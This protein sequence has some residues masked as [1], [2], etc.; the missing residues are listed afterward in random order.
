MAA[1]L[2]VEGKADAVEMTRALIADPELPAKLRQ[3]RISDI[4]PCL[5]ANQDNIIGLVQNPRLSCA[6]NPSAGYEQEAEFAPL[7]PAR[8]PHRCSSS[9]VGRQV[10]KRHGLLPCA[11]IA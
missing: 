3:G 4:R 11:A 6:N 7:K 2:L 10:W 5:L 8:V 1:T 9:A